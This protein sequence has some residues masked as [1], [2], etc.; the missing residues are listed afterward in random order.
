MLNS[1][2][3]MHLQKLFP[4]GVKIANEDEPIIFGKRT[5]AHGKERKWKE[6]S[7]EQYHVCC[8]MCHDERFRLYISYAWGMDNK[9]KFPTSKLVIC[10]NERCHE[11]I[12]HDLPDKGNV[13]L[14]LERRLRASYLRLIG[15]GTIVITPV[16]KDRRP[17][18]LI[19][20]PNPTWCTKLTDMGPEHPAARYLA[21]RNFQVA[22]LAKWGVV[23]AD[24]YPVQANGKDYSWLAGRLFIPT[25]GNGWQARDLEGNT[26]VKYFSCPGWKKSEQLYGL[27]V[28]RKSSPEFVLL[29]EGV[30]DVWRVGGPGVAIFGKSLSNIQVMKLRRN[31]RTIGVLLDP[32]TETDEVNSMRRAMNQLSNVGM[33]VFRVTLPGVK[34]AADCTEQTLWKHIE[35]SA[36][37]AGFQDVKRPQGS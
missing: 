26:K 27:N 36:K 35:A 23:Y 16:V 24:Q 25:P 5:D 3:Y 33:Q 22:D 21:G 8:P 9:Q 31:W 15:N 13:G 14:F 12:D 20:F 37:K 10:H 1:A 30:T 19:P 32:D 28:A 34:D 6:Q 2:L 29:C 18:T 4:E 17:E 7:G 11:R